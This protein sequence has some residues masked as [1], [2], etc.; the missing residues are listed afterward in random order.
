MPNDQHS[1]TRLF[2]MVDVDS[3]FAYFCLVKMGKNERNEAASVGLCVGSSFLGSFYNTFMLSCRF[4]L[5]LL[6]PHPKR[7]FS[8]SATMGNDRGRW[9]RERRK[10]EVLNTIPL[11]VRAPESTQYNILYYFFTPSMNPSQC[12]LLSH[13]QPF[14]FFLF[15]IFF[16]CFIQWKITRNDWA[17]ERRCRAL[18]LFYALPDNLA[19]RER[20]DTFGF[21]ALQTMPDGFNPFCSLN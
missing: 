4:F 13:K 3:S 14:H 19:C 7:F 16:L 12:S 2:G 8:A 21:K 10:K 15:V 5:P 17:L 11:L 18:S 6:V 1:R 9:K 20:S